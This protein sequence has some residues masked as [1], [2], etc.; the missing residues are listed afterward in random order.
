MPLVQLSSQVLKEKWHKRGGNNLQGYSRLTKGVFFFWQEDKNEPRRAVAHKSRQNRNSVSQRWHWE[1]VPSVDCGPSFFHPRLHPLIHRL[2]SLLGP[3]LPLHSTDAHLVTA[4]LP[5]LSNRGKHG[6]F[7][8]LHFA[9]LRSTLSSQNDLSAKPTMLT[10]PVLNPPVLDPAGLA[11]LICLASS[12]ISSLFLLHHQPSWGALFVC[13]PCTWTFLS[14]PLC[15]LLRKMEVPSPAR[16][17]P[18]LSP[19]LSVTLVSL[20]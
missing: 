10:L 11:L 19:L 13:L 16:S 6:Q 15:F 1:T 8:C 9:P 5:E 3:P 4:S 18:N 20:L 7:L 17:H 12:L 14:T 2:A